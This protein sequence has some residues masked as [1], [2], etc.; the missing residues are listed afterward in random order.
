MKKLLCCP[1]LF[2]S[3]HIHAGNLDSLSRKEQLG[4]SIIN[5]MA[6]QFFKGTSGPTATNVIS[7]SSLPAWYYSYYGTAKYQPGYSLHARLYLSSRLDK[8]VSI[9]TGIGYLFQQFT[10]YM[11]YTETDGPNTKNASNTKS[12][13]I[14]KLSISAH[15]KFTKEMSKGAFTCS[16]GPDL[17]FDIHEG[18]NLSHVLINGIP[19][20]NQKSHGGPDGKYIGGLGATLKTGYQKTLSQNT[21]IDIGP[22]ISFCDLAIF[23]SLLKSESLISS[24]RP[25]SYYTGLDIAFNFGL[26]K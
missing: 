13:F 2:V 20:P 14:G 23:K 21:T 25:F 19:Q 12:E 8:F 10:S 24:Y 18:Q 17:Y 9:E 6:Q 5:G 16:L 3:M 1:L 15:V 22:I 4:L 11:S 7:S 26:K